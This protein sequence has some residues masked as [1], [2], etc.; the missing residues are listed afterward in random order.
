MIGPRK[1]SVRIG[2]RKKLTELYS[3]WPYTN[4]TCT[5]L[6]YFSGLR[7]ARALS[8]LERPAFPAGYVLLDSTCVVC[9]QDVSAIQRTWVSP[10]VTFEIFDVE[11]DWVIT[12]KTIHFWAAGTP[13]WRLAGPDSAARAQ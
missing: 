6:S 11:D 7:Y 9:G 1:Y 2:K 13:F 12:P 10:Y 3:F 4:H 8:A 5:N